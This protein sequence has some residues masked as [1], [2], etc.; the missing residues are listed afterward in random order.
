[1]RENTQSFP[2]KRQIVKE[3][4]ALIGSNLI[5]LFFNKSLLCILSKVTVYDCMIKTRC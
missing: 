1:M 5:G 3:G 4:Q 2:K